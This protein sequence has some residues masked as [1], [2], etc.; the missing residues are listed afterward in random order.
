MFDV[1]CRVLRAA[2]GS[3]LWLVARDISVCANLRRELAQRGLDAQR[4]VFAGMMPYPQHLARLSLADLFL[5][6]F[7]FSA[8][9]TASDALWAGVPLLTCVGEAYSSRMAGSLLRSLDLP[10]LITTSLADYER[11]ALELA[12]ASERLAALRQR[13]QE[14]RRSSATFDT[15]RFCRGLERAYLTM[16]ERAERGEPPQG[17][18]LT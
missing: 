13:L 1:W 16:W 3:V 15:A 18:A 8:G 7:P 2:P 4:L 11:R 6:T 9:A 12:C 5:D 10:E 17:F 14:N